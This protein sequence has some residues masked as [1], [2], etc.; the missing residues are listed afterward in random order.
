LTAYGTEGEAEVAKG[1]LKFTA[2]RQAK[3]ASHSRYVLLPYEHS[4]FHRIWVN[5]LTFYRIA[6]ATD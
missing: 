2:L 5:G 1:L 4:R 3:N 6:G